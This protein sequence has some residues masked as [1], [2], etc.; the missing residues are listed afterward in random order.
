[1]TGVTVDDSCH[2]DASVLLGE[3]SLADMKTNAD[4]SLANV[5]TDAETSLADVITADERPTE[6][7][8]RRRDEPSDTRPA[9]DEHCQQG[10][11]CT[12][13]YCTVLYC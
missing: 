10:V 1:M 7:Q 13:L 4:V 11:Y 6:I 5:K 3:T 12:V 9:V 2:D 8:Q